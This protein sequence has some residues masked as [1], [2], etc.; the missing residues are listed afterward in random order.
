MTQNSLR[1][2]G[3]FWALDANL[4]HRRHFPAINWIKSYTL[5]ID[6]VQNWYLTNVA[7]DWKELRDRAMFLLQK[8][9]EL[10]EIV[11]L[12]GPDA[13]PETE[14]IILEVTKMIR[15]DFLQQFAFHEID[16]YCSPKKQYWMLKVIINFYNATVEAVERGITLQQVFSLTLKSEIARMK[17]VPLDKA[18]EALSHLSEKIVK[19]IVMLEVL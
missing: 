5:Y 10:Q 17:E 13:L 6:Q 16:A 2:S 14:K 4:A 7:P 12:V 18:E 3:A 8:E 15:E 19:D 9:V 1:I 11:Q